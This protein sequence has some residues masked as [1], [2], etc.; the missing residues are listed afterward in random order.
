[1]ANPS[2]DFEKWGESQGEDIES[3][4]RELAALPGYVVV[5]VKPL[6]EALPQSEDVG[7]ADFEEFFDVVEN[8]IQVR[9]RVGYI[10][11]TTNEADKFF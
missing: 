9:Y 3:K 7:Y 4:V 5:Y 8:G 6:D 1:M 11:D 2:K 10:E